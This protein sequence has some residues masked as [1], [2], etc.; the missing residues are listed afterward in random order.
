M[1]FSAPSLE[2]KKVQIKPKVS[3]IDQVVQDLAK[4]DPLKNVRSNVKSTVKSTVKSNIIPQLTKGAAIGQIQGSSF[5]KS[6]QRNIGN[7][8]KGIT[9]NPQLKGSLSNVKGLFIDPSK[10]TKFPRLGPKGQ[11]LKG[12]TGG[13]IK[14]MPVVSGAF[15]VADAVKIYR[16]SVNQGYTKREAYLRAVSYTHLTLPTKA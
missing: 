12:I 11:R 8:Y 15:N 14:G 13:K 1:T 16:E 7:L 6:S 10:S 9:T 3:K 4:K 5:I 2:K